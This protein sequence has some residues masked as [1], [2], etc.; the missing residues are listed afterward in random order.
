LK[1][2]LDDGDSESYYTYERF[3]DYLSS[4]RNDGQ[5]WSRASAFFALLAAGG[6]QDV[7]AIAVFE[8]LCA[9]PALREKLMSNAGP[10]ARKLLDAANC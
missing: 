8:P 3:A 4:R 10:G 5:L 1:A 9:D 2:E 6:P 7:L